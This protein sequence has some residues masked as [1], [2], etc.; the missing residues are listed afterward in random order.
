MA[1]LNLQAYNAT[2]ATGER[3]SVTFDISNFLP[4]SD[5]VVTVRRLQAPGADIKAANATTWAGQTFAEGVASG[6]FVEEKVSNGLVEV[7]ASGA[8]LVILEL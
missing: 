1:L 5:T 4:S 6:E 3:P 2:D 7:E 8:A